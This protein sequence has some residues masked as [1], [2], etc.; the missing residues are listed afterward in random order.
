[1]KT[2]T[3]L[4]TDSLHFP[5]VDQ[6]FDDPPGLL[7]AGGDLRPD[8]LLAAYARGIFPWYDDDS[9]ILWWS[10]DPRMVLPPD[11]VHV[12]RSLAKLIR[13]DRYRITMD[14]A[15]ADVIGH[16]AGL[17]AD[18]EGT[19][20][21]EEMQAAYRE[22]HRLGHA[23]SVEVWQADRLV[24]GLY[25]IAM[26][27]LFFGESMF[28]LAAS[29]SKIAFVALARQLQQWE[30]ALIDCQMPTD[31]LQS[32]GACEMSRAE[33]QDVL[34]RWRDDETQP[35]QWTFDNNVLKKH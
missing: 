6:A 27:K 13:Q 29:T 30:F 28:S 8:R 33:F 26:G 23:H 9:P 24:G 2:I 16:C 5:P 15:F 14:T 1:M 21:T 4:G 12:S 31:H 17:R 25:G 3:W 34:Q 10:P 32:L 19:W 11:A 35:G 7:A 18:R 20:I 22:L